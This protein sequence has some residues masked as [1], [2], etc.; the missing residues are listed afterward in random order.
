M[1]KEFGE[2]TKW[3]LLQIDM[4]GVIK[5]TRNMD[6]ANLYGNQVIPTKG[7]TNMMKGTV[8]EKC[9]SQM[10]QFTK[11]TGIEVFNVVK[12]KCT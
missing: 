5:M 4:K 6:K 7:T 2:K 10:E 8:M 12:L 3:I 9:I 1:V 11:A